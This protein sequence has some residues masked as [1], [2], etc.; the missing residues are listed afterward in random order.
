MGKI[1]KCRILLSEGDEI[2]VKLIE[3]DKKT[4]KTSYLEKFTRKTKT[5]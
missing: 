5:N 2:E 1:R 4:G 3:K